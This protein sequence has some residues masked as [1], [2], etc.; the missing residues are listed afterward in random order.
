ME[1]ASFF[2]G[3]LVMEKRYSGQREIAPNKN[4]YNILASSKSLKN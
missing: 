4:N 3:G 2:C 1:T